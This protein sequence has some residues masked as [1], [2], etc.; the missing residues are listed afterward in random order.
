M[1]HARISVV[2]QSGHSRDTFGKRSVPDSAI[3]AYQ[4]YQTLKQNEPQIE[5]TAREPNLNRTWY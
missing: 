4:L 3:P 2:S 1:E 5:R